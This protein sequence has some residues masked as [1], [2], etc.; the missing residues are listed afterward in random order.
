M[1]ISLYVWPDSNE[2][3]FL[4]NIYNPSYSSVIFIADEWIGTTSTGA[5]CKT[6][7]QIKDAVTGAS[8]DAPIMN[9]Y[10]D[11]KDFNTPIKEYLDDRLYDYP[12]YD[13]RKYVFT[14]INSLIGNLL[15][16]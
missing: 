11:G 1:E 9:G 2:F 10:F 6:S 7:N 4:G 13:Q 12:I 3:T 14:N 16:L 8:F 15:R 5:A